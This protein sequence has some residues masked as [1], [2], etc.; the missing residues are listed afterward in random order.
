MTNSI[1]LLFS[2]KIQSL[3]LLSICLIL[4]A[5]GDLIPDDGQVNQ[6]PPQ[7]NESVS[8]QSTL[9]TEPAVFESES[10]DA[11]CSSEELFCVALVELTSEL[12]YFEIQVL[13][14]LDRAEV[15]LAAQ[16]EQR[17]ILVEESAA[18]LQ[19]LGQAG[20][21]VVITIGD[22]LGKEAII[23]YS[24]FSQTRFVT[25]NQSSYFAS[26]GH[27]IELNFPEYEAGFLGGVI[28]AHLTDSNVVAI[29]TPSDSYS[30]QLGDG[31]VDG[32]LSID[33]SIKALVLTE[34][35]DSSNPD[36]AQVKQLVSQVENEGADVVLAGGGVFGDLILEE[37]ASKSGIRCVGIVEDQWE[38]LPNAQSC[39]VTSIVF[40]LELTLID[41]MA[42]I[43]L[44][45][46]NPEFHVPVS[47]G[48][49][50]Y[51]PF[52]EYEQELTAF[53]RA[54]I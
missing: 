43:A 35:G 17:Q 45:P 53:V 7:G 11:N 14:A 28:A 31:F 20:Y 47:G 1:Q 52:R 33:E 49:V 24:K 30:F 23:A 41:T 48:F 46:N 22:D 44:K 16:V 50:G 32:A 39:L 15:D 54:S 26:S 51:A 10:A 29:I 19:E 2:Q 34:I 27:L 12:D 42:R 5:C 4:V 21:D 36:A 6:L 13:E 9:E 8:E 40:Q 38:R 25:V 18:T 3:A 37:I